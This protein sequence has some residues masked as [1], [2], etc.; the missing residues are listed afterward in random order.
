[1]AGYVRSDQGVIQEKKILK[2]ERESMYEMEKEKSK[3]VV[4]S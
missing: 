3:Y 4:E 1:M 2:D